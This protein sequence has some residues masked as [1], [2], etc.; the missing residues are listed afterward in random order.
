MSNEDCFQESIFSDGSLS[1]PEIIKPAE[2]A[3]RIKKI[4][5]FKY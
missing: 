4:S 2:S 1:L 3:E 5:H